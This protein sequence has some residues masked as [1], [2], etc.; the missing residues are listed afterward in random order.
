MHACARVTF[1]KEPLAHVVQGA[2]PVAED[3]PA[4]HKT[5]QSEDDVDPVVTVERPDA[6]GKQL[7]APVEF[8]NEPIEQSPHGTK[9]L[10]ANVPMTHRWMQSATS[11]APEKRVEKP[12]A[13]GVHVVCWVADWYVPAVQ[14]VQGASPSAERAPATQ[15]ARHAVEDVDPVEFVV[16]PSA[17]AKQSVRCVAF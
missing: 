17:Q 8:E 15:G 3:W 9:P 12:A 11:V 4:T 10:E 16:V 1:E 6:Q 2:R 13:Q 14:L 7:V 5:R